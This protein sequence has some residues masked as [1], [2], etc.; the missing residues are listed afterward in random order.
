MIR[1]ISLDLWKTL[2]IDK[3][4]DEALRDRIRAHAIFCILAERGILASE[5]TL[6]AS[7][8]RIDVLRSDVREMPDWTITTTNQIRFVL[9]QST[10]YPTPDLV[11]AI[12]PRYDSAILDRLPSL[13]EPDA[14]HTLAALSAAYPLSLT[15]NTGKTPGHILLHVLDAFGI[16]RFF[17]HFVFSDEIMCVKPQQ[18]I[19]DY[20]ISVNG[21]QPDEILHV[22]DSYSVDYRGALEAGFRAVLFGCREPRG[23]DVR[24]IDSLNELTHVIQEM[25][26]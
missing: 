10:I 24:C 20:L 23:H 13:L 18:G 1:A 11:D 4:E 3:P 9:T 22:G 15:S 5:E 19:W 17:S 16:R 21:V 25:N 26:A 7:L 8:R 2:I 12:V 14:P 6:Y